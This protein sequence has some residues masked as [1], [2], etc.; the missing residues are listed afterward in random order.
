VTGRAGEGP[1]GDSALGA[2]VGTQ[3]E[4]VSTTLRMLITDRPRS[5]IS[6]MKE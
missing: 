4:K 6:W 1:R 5:S 3:L 2:E